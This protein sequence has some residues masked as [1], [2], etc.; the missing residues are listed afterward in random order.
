MK[1]HDFVGCI[2]SFI[3]N[4]QDK[5]KELPITSQ[6]ITDGCPRISTVDVCAGW[7]CQNGGVCVRQWEG[8]ECSCP[9]KYRGDHCEEG[10][11]NKLFEC[12][13]TGL[14][15]QKILA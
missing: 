8:P 13:I 11:I 14:D 1:S 12:K 7:G 5:L 9:V 4:G 6:G 10:S 15:E 2:R 3:I